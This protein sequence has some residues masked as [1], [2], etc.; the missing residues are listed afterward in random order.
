MNLNKGNLGGKLQEIRM[1]LRGSSDFLE[2]GFFWNDITPQAQ[3]PISLIQ[4]YPNSIDTSLKKTLSCKDIWYI[5]SSL[6]QSYL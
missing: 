6:L 2:T 1:F 5:L 3:Y 4:S